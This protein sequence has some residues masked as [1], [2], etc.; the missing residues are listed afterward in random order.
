[1]VTAVLEAMGVLVI[2]I[3]TGGAV[4]I[5]LFRNGVDPSL[6]GFC[7]TYTL[8]LPSALMW[9]IRN[10]ATAETELVAVERIV[11]YSQIE[12]EDENV[13]FSSPK[14]VCKSD[15]TSEKFSQL[16]NDDL[17]STSLLRNHAAFEGTVDDV[18]DGRLEFVNVTM[19]YRR[20]LNPVLKKVNF[21][22][23]GGKKVA[24]IG[25]TGAGKSSIFMA[26]LR[27]YGC[28]DGSAIYL[29]GKNIVSGYQDISEYRKN[30]AYVPQEAVLL[31]GTLRTSLTKHC[32]PDQPSNDKLIWD[33]LEKV[34]MKAK[35]KSM[36][37]GL[38]TEVVEGGVNFS[39][40]ERQLLCLARALLNKR[41][42][43]VLADEATANI[44]YSSELLVQ[45]V[46]LGLPMTVLY[47]CH[48]LVNLNQFDLVM[49]MENGEVNKICKPEDHLVG[50]NK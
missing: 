32:T 13:V 4:Y 50:A 12:A 7:L 28:K 2:L 15:E 5:H 17:K 23:E 33:A 25:R 27:F 34:K 30:I 21:A 10:L 16:M 45:Q 35:I 37:N 46:V 48:R 20:N 18:L 41:A 1:M 49:V 14:S 3:S 47:I 6:I 43:V 24:I 19:S 31:S 44:D 36:E 22:I 9:L 29:N 11:E 38:D 8:N 42:S 26:L 39:H 40:G